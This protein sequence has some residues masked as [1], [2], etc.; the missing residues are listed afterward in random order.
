M[1]SNGGSR[2]RRPGGRRCTWDSVLTRRAVAAAM[3][4]NSACRTP[5]PRRARRS[6][7]SSWSPRSS[8]VDCGRRS[9]APLAGAEVERSLCVSAAG[10]VTRE[11]AAGR[12]R[13]A[14]GGGEPS[15]PPHA[16]RAIVDRGEGGLGGS[17]G[18]HRRK[19]TSHVEVAAAQQRRRCCDLATGAGVL[20][21]MLC[22]ARRGSGMQIRV[23][24]PVEV[25]RDGVLVNVG[26]PQQRRLLALLVLHRGQAVS[27]DRVVDAL[28]PDGDA[29]EGAVALDAHVP[30][31][32]SLR[33]AGRLDHHAAG[34]YCST[35]RRPRRRRRVRRA[36]R[37]GRVGGARPRPRPVR[38]GAGP[39]GA[40]IRS[41]SSPASGGRCRSRHGCRA[42]RTSAELGSAPRPRS[43][44]VTTTGRSPTSSGW[45]PSTRS[46]SDP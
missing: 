4:S 34:G 21:R 30:L 45:P 31:A 35:Q 39:R 26:G 8:V 25:E 11:R 15:V 16:A 9:P 36:D 27:T 44:S 20:A 6:A 28:W 18:A 32:P 17:G 1:A 22:R 46:T 24:G 43:R 41:A 23:L 2:R 42:M 7:T 3:P 40:V 38:R 12:G 29:P 10:A 37:R 14:V 5:P 19:D 33:A 13:G